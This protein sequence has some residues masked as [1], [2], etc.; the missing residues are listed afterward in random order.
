MSR[1]K[2]PIIISYYTDNWEYP[3]RA[4][5]LMADCDT[6]NID[7]HIVQMP[8]TGTWIQNTRLK[9]TF[10]H[11]QLERLKRPVLWI[12]ADSRLLQ[13]PHGILK[14][15]DFA[16]VRAKSPT[17]KVFYAGTLY[18]N[19]TDA[20]RDFARR[21]AECDVEG[22][23]HTALDS[24]WHQGFDGI[25]HC[26]PYSYCQVEIRKDVTDD[27]VIVSGSSTDPSKQAYFRKNP[28]SGSRK[29]LAR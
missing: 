4:E 23:D 22:S 14:Y 9:A 26:L 18:F 7:H 3:A 20:G 2:S 13:S 21:W 24:V 28:Y 17:S 25:V 16:G 29:R 8:D 19:Y 15:A 11:E 1:R 12:D 10:V 5:Q 27:A 6:F